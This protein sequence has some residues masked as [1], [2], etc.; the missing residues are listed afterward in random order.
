MRPHG[1]ASVDPSNPACWASCDRCGLLYNL[2]ALSWQLEWA[3]PSLINKRL[4]V[5]SKCLDTPNPQ[6]RAL[7]LPPDPPPIFNARPEPYSIDEDGIY[8]FA[9]SMFYLADTTV[10]LADNGP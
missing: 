10:G 8:A 6:L 4:L 7:V 3:G 9:D 2:N 5:C 1:R